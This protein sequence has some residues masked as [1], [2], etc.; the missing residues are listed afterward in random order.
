MPVPVKVIL[1]VEAIRPVAVIEEVCISPVFTTL[2][3]FIGC[4][5]ISIKSSSITGPPFAVEIDC[6]P[7]IAE[8]PFPTISP[9]FKIFPYVVLTPITLI[10]SILPP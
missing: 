2:Q 8:V 7:K 9:K 5:F 4:W 3:S 6:I 10:K 1:P